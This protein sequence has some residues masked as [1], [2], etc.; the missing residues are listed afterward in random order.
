MFLVSFR[1]RVRRPI[2][3]VVYLALCGLLYGL[4]L[5]ALLI[6]LG[7]CPPSSP[8][9]PTRELTVIGLVAAVVL[10]LRTSIE[11]RR[12]HDMSRSGWWA[13][14]MLIAMV[15]LP[16]LVLSRDASDE[17]A[18]WVP[19]WYAVSVAYFLFLALSRGAPLENRYGARPSSA[20]S[21]R[22]P[23]R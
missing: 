15:G 18:T 12:L 19:A 16:V 1:G 14:S 11:V 10:A 21:L 13:F 17:S 8:P 9:V 4:L 22:T 2:F 5:L 20:W 3:V 23:P 6:A 7:P